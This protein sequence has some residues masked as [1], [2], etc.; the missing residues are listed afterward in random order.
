MAKRTAYLHVGLP[1]SGG[2]RLDAALQVHADALAASGVRV[3][4][5]S[6]D[7]MFRASVEIR[8]DHKAWGLRRKDVE[9]VWSGICRRAYAGKDSVVVGHSLLAGA[10]ETEIDLLVDRLPGFAVHVVVTV[11]AP[12]ARLS[13]FP[14]DHDLSD[15]LRRWDRAVC[16]PDRMHVV[17][18][19]PTD[20]TPAWQA[21]GQVVGFEATGLDLP[22][23]T[24]GEV[25][26]HALRLIAEGTSSLSVH[27]DLG[28]VVQEW[29]KV[30]AD[31]GYD[32][33]GDLTGLVATVGADSGSQRDDLRVSLLSEALSD[34]IAE[35]TRLRARTR[36][37]E[38][39]NA[40]LTKK[41]RKLKQ[42]LLDAQPA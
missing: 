18:C 20:P 27:G 30:V 3:P 4:S 24:V 31:A 2:D 29:A 15:V 11:A 6:V 39:D 21:L 16:S 28:V 12:D 5:T 25:D 17:V 8:R 7:E 40:T 13:A 22:A 34:S 36:D 23:A 41:K 38:R 19:D 14:D 1:H 9:G 35:V 32:V 42:R 26:T 37:L 33:R 10:T